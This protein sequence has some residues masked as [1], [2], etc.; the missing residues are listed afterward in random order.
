MTSI[1]TSTAVYARMALGHGE[2]APVRAISR[3]ADQ[4]IAGQQGASFAAKGHGNQ[5]PAHGL[6]APANVVDLPIS[7]R[8]AVEPAIRTRRLQ[9]PQ[10]F[11]PFLAQQ[12]AQEGLSDKTKAPRQK[13]EA[14][15][16][17]YVLASDDEVKILGP[18]RP[19]ELVV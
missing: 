1:G 11:T 6:R 4:R 3:P 5:A 12:I 10:P 19:R 13:H 8:A 2:V 9:A 7:N 16:E 14:V 17:A 15:S 18:V